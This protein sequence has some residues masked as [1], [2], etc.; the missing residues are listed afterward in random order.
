[1]RVFTISILAVAICLSGC[2]GAPNFANVTGK[3]WKLIQVHVSGSPVN[4][5]VIYDRNDLRRE[6]IGNIYTLNFD[7][8]NIN[9]VGAPNRYS[10][11][12]SIRENLGI[13]IKDIRSTMMASL[14]QPEKLQEHVYF[15]YLQNAY[16]WN[17]VNKNLE[18]NSKTEDGND[19][20][21]VFEL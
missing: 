14:I 2:A 17:I 10:A 20:R 18:I 7:A 21:L 12:Y 11:P 6:S 1:M 9:G 4:R 5:T 19:V 15:L 13:E 16:S 8:E 3:E